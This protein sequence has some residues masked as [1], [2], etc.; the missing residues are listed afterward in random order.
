[1]RDG[2]VRPT[3]KALKLPILRMAELNVAWLPVL[4]DQ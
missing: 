1:L 4:Y 2:K 3:T